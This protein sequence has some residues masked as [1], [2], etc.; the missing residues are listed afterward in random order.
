MSVRLYYA[1]LAI[2]SDILLSGIK[3]WIVASTLFSM[4]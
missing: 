2:D 4:A 3:I 1:A